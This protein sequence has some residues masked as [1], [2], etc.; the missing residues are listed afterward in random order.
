METMGNSIFVKNFLV[1]RFGNHVEKKIHITYEGNDIVVY[2]NNFDIFLEGENLA[3]TIASKI[4]KRVFIR[5]DPNSLVSKEF[6]EDFIRKT[7]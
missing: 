4:K 7:I 1:E 5:F 6:A 3:K 2:T